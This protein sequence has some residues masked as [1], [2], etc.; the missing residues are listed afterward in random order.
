VWWTNSLTGT[1]ASVPFSTFNFQFSINLDHGDNL[2]T[3]SGTNIYGQSTNSVVS[4]HRKTWSEATPRI[5]TNALIFPNMAAVL[6]APMPTNI[7]WNV[8]KITDET[9]QTNLTITKISVLLAGNSNEVATVTNDVSNLLGEIGW[10]VPESLIGNDTNYV[11]KFDVVDS[12]SLTNSRIFQNNLFQIVPEAFF[13]AAIVGFLFYGLT[14]R[15]RFY[16]D[17]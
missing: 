1:S 11:L 7:I 17:N 4:I 6:L 8:S 15:S 10:F 12:S 9:D 13:G 14:H 5:E 2:I 16:S 3:V